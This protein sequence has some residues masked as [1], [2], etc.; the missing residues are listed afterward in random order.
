MITLG[1]TVVEASTSVHTR[2]FESEYYKPF[3]YSLWNQDSN[4]KWLQPPKPTCSPIKMFHDVDYWEKV[5]TR[6][7]NKSIFVNSGYKT[8]L[9]EIEIAFDAADS[10][11]MEKDV[12]LQKGGFRK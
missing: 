10:M 1:D 2:Y 9:N 4:M 5:D 11:R 8:N 6:D 12:F 3:L 7:Y